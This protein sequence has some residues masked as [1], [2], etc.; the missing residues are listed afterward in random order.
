M[1][2]YTIG[3][4]WNR[5]KIEGPLVCC[6]MAPEPSALIVAI[7]LNDQLDAETRY[8]GRYNPYCD[9]KLC[10]H[11]VRRVHVSTGLALGSTRRVFEVHLTGLALLIV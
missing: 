6:E 5:R 8:S 4:R 11:W 9:A 7:L 1:E 2:T 10:R 3:L